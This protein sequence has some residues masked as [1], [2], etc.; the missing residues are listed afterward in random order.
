MDISHV[1]VNGQG[2][3]EGGGEDGQGGREGA[4]LRTAHQLGVGQHSFPLPANNILQIL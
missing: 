1:S 4:E 3:R 2:G